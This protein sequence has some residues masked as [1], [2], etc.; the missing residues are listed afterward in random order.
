LTA[1]LEKEKSIKDSEQLDAG[2]LNLET[3]N[4]KPEK[5]QRRKRRRTSKRKSGEKEEDGY[6]FTRED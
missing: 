6:V 5:K 2:T 4:N 1:A 3:L